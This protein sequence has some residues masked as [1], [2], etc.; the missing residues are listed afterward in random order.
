MPSSADIARLIVKARTPAAKALLTEKM[1]TQKRIE[2]QEADVTALRAQ[3][4]GCRACGLGRSR[5]R[6]VPWSGP[7]GGRA[8]LVIV[9]EAPGAEEDSKGVPFVGRSG[10]LLDRLLEQAGTHRDRCFVANTLCCR[11]PENR[12]PR[13]RELAACRPN[14]DAQL[15]MSGVWVGVALGAYALANVMGK[16]RGAIS[17]GDYLDTPIWVDR[18]IWIASYHPAYALRNVVE[19]STIKEAIQWALAIRFGDLAA[20][21]PNWPEVVIDGKT[22]M[23]EHLKKKGWALVNS[24]AFGAQIVVV[25]EHKGKP[26]IPQAISHLTVYT[27]GELERIGLMS[28]QKGWTVADARRMHILK[29]EFGGEII[30]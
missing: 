1:Q 14:F 9:G 8:D 27:M 19:Q 22:G 28:A 2:A 5:T 7:V 11:P 17:I 30:V 3:I 4:V 12:D 25:D 16:D 23:G 10:K 29:S 20:P 13:P 26:R 15:D 6:A 24:Q 18:R 21:K